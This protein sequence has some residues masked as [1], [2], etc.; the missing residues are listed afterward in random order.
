MNS[1]LV[2]V[3]LSL[4]II[5]TGFWFLR[6][7]KAPQDLSETPVVEG[8]TPVGQTS[9]SSVNPQTGALPATISGAQSAPAAAG[10]TSKDLNQFLARFD[11]K[12]EW[13]INRGDNGQVI[14]FSGG[15]IEGISQSPEKELAFARE[16]AELT[17][18]SG[19]QVIVSETKLEQTPYTE[20]RQ[21]DQEVGG[22][23]VF[24]GYMKIFHRKSDGAV[25]Y[26][27][28]ETRNVGDVDLR[29]RYSFADAKAAALR[30]HANK[31]GVVVENNPSKPVIYSSGP[32][33]GELAWEV[34]IRIQGPL[35]DYR[36]LLVS[37]ISGQILKDITLLKN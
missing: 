34:L 31:T 24:G 23:Q 12:A 21:Y 33:H 15:L 7:P 6:K 3:I 2:V 28:N 17:G 20:A 19:D 27:A 16:F 11:K 36:H 1:K 4:V 14:A 37:A 5:A 13:R 22:Y 8:T 18:V 26:V 10:G 30:Q 9:N 32:G 35:Y 29:I 25:Y